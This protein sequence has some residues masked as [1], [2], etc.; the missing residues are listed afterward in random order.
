MGEIDDWSAHILVVR[1]EVGLA[2]KRIS[3]GT[4]LGGAVFVCGVCVDG[5]VGSFW[6]VFRPIRIQQWN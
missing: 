3:P 5:R 2:G 4:P 1:S 6:W